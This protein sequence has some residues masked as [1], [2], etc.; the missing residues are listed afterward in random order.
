VFAEGKSFVVRNS[1]AKIYISVEER[2]LVFG[3][4]S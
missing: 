2:L 3:L 1:V 4:G